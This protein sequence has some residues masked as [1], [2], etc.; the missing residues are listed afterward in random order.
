MSINLDDIAEQAKTANK[1]TLQ[2]FVK[3]LVA[4]VDNLRA[5]Y[6]ACKVELDRLRGVA[7]REE[8]YKEVVNAAKQ[9]TTDQYHGL[10]GSSAHSHQTRLIVALR[11]LD[12][13]SK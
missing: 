4:E 6:E 8:A 11:V 2:T 9:F 13:V 5:G 12:A 1:D 7:R 10:I 3:L